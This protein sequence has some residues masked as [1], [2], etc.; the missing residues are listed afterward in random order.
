[1]GL[2]DSS[3]EE[4]KNHLTYKNTLVAIKGLESATENYKKGGGGD[5]DAT[6]L[7]RAV[8]KVFKKVQEGRDQFPS[9]GEWDGMTTDAKELAGAL[10]AKH[11]DDRYV[12][13]LDQYL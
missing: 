4:V 5:N 1:M 12:K 11:P 10:K 2:L 6:S 8:A 9:F 7:A 3:D 13:E